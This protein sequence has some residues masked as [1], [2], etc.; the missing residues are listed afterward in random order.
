MDNGSLGMVNSSMGNQ[1]FFTAGPGEEVDKNDKET[2]DNINLSNKD[3]A[4]SNTEN[5]RAGGVAMNSIKQGEQPASQETLG[6]V[7]SA[8]PNQSEALN[9]GILAQDNSNQASK[10]INFDDFTS[11]GD[12]ISKET[13]NTVTHVVDD[14]KSGKIS[15]ATL[16]EAEWEG[17]KAY[18]KSSF[19][20]DLAA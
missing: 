15:P 14:F 19:G 4:W 17:T 3:A 2:I 6:E 7:V 8:D 5:R 13:L 20:R 16:D 9:S 10:I 18:V 11:K 1:P 12:K